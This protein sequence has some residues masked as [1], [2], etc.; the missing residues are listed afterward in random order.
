MSQVITRFAP[1][2]TGHFHIGGVRSALYSFLYAR[3]NNGKFILRSEDTDPNRSKREF[4]DEFLSV[5]DWLGLRHDEFFRQSDRIEIYRKYIQ[6]LIDEDLAYISKE[7]PTEAGQRSEVIRLRNPGKD[8]TFNDLIL[9]DITFNTKELGD[10][11]IARDINSPLYHLTVVVD[12]FE[13]KVTHIIRGQEHVSNTPR[14]ILIQEAIGAN[15]PFYAHIPLILGKDKSKLSKRDPEV[16]PAIDYKDHGYLPGA[17]LNFMALIGWNPGGEQEIF[18]LEELIEAFT[19]EKVQKGGGVFNVEKLNW[20]N[21][22]HL[23]KLTEQE[24]EEFV[25]KFIPKDFSEKNNQY[26]EKIIPII[27]ERI[28]NGIEI[29]ELIESGEFNFLADNI[30]LD[31]NILNWNGKQD[32]S[33]TVLHLQTLMK[34]MGNI[35]YFVV[36]KIKQVCMSYANTQEKRG[37]VLHPMRYALTGQEKSPDPFIVSFIL[38]KNKSIERFRKAIDLLK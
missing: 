17:I 8:I 3:K 31:K 29:K 25:K 30:D 21:K 23:K 10:F 4:E 28:S 5:F 6:K 14:Q 9:G 38:G 11:V 1:S 22:E 33:V 36:E 27:F 35:D 16:I 13:M 7:E 15:R 32:S 18:S 19:L 12:D 34:E 2:P 26:I 24:I 20:V 37:A